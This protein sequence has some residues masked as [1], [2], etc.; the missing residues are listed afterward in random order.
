MKN[1]E[2]ALLDTHT[3]LKKKKKH[4]SYQIAVLVNL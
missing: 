1:Y 4:S 3:H 2:T